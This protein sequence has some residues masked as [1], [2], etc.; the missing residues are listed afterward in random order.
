MQAYDIVFAGTPEFAAQHL[1]ALLDSPHRIIGVYTQPDRAAGRGKQLQASA[2]KRLALENGLPVYQPHSLRGVEDQQVLASLNPDLLIVV[3]YGLI[4]PQAVLDIPPLGCLNVHASLLPR[5]RGAAPIERALLAGDERTGV[6][7]MQMDKGLDT[8][9]M[10]SKA[11]IEIRDEDD[12]QSLESRL[13][14]VGTQALIESL[15]Q[16]PTLQA[17]AQTQDDSLSTYAAKLDKE[18]ALIDWNQPAALINRTIRGGIGRN[19]A[20]CFL[21]AE[22]V[23]IIKATPLNETHSSPAGM[24]LAHGHDSLRVAC[25]DSVLEIHTMQFPGK[26]VQE[27]AVLLN[28]RQDILAPGNYLRSHIEAQP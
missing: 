23:R 8:G 17:N 9:A 4:L 24:I 16:L 11:T 26:T 25:K 15:A 1:R 20:Y 27:V 2:V 14:Q 22:R 12:R 18:E 3:A 7:I 10:L 6:T 21:N 19:P 5:W 13:A 28:S